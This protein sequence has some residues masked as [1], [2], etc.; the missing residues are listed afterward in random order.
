MNSK[1]IELLDKIN[2]LAGSGNLTDLSNL[3]YDLLKEYT[4]NFYDML[5]DER[6]SPVRLNNTLIENKADTDIQPNS[7]VVVT[8]PVKIAMELNETIAEV[9][10]DIIKQ[11]VRTERSISE[12]VENAESLND[13][14]KSASTVEIHKKLS[15]KPLKELIDLNKK[16][17]FLNE[18]FQGDFAVFSDAIARIDSFSEFTM[19]ESFV[20]MEYATKYKWDESTQSVRLFYKLMR[21]KFGVE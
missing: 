9:K 6:M 5:L 10:P 13:R 8:E 2:R 11:E 18:L 17:V 14:L 16:F 1:T 20:K 3:E 19:A 21:Q 4:R 12:M 7:V 15:S